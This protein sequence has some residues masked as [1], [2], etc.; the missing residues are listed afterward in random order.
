MIDRIG[1]C[2][3]CAKV[4]HK[5]HDVSYAKYGS[6]FC[7]CGAKE[8][9]S[10]KALTKRQG[11]KNQDSKSKKSSS[12]SSKPRGDSNNLQKLKRTKLASSSSSTKFDSNLKLSETNVLASTEMNSTI[13]QPSIDVKRRLVWQIRANKSKQIEKLR[14]EIIQIAKDKNLIEIVKRFISEVLMPVAKQKYDSSLLVTNFLISRS[15][16][17]QLKG[18]TFELPDYV[19]LNCQQQDEVVKNST[20][21]LGRKIKINF[22]D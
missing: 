18:A 17:A 22:I 8:D 21:E 19:R 13:S 9:G 10:C 11:S 3:I 15:Y 4:C 1:M 16:L 2:T 7:D 20:S 14:S 6:F 12:K 5:G